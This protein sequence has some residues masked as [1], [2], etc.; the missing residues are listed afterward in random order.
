MTFIR[1]DL[2]HDRE[3]VLEPDL[4]RG[5]R[6]QP[7]IMTIIIRLTDEIKRAHIQVD[8]HVRAPPK[9]QASPHIRVR[10]QAHFKEETLL[11]MMA[12]WL[13][14]IIPSILI[15]ADT[16]ESRPHMAEDV[17]YHRRVVQAVIPTHTVIQTRI[18]INFMAAHIRI[19]IMADIRRPNICQILNLAKTIT[20]IFNIVVECHHHYHHI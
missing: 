20:N 6:R 9:S 11:V 13:M 12:I 8:I 1:I 10:K 7:Q 18:V 2:N 19:L 5:I 15:I 16:H 3:L 14:K 17:L 4:D